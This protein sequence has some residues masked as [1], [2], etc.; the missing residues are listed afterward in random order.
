[1]SRRRHALS[2]LAAV[3]A[4]LV[5]AAPAVAQGPPPPTS[6]SGATVE[7]VAHGVTTPTSFAFAGATVF[8]GSGPN[9]DRKHNPN[10][11]T[12]LFTLAGGAATKVPGTPGVV[13]GLAYQN[14]VLYISTFNRILAYRG[15]NGTTFSGHSVIARAAGKLP[16]F[17]GLAF[18]PNGRLYVGASLDAKSDAKKGPGRYA[19]TVISMRPNGHRWLIVAR[20]LRQPFQ[21][22]FPDGQTSPFV[23]DLAQETGR[24]PDDQVVVAKTG[25]NFGFPTCER[26]ALSECPR[27]TKPFVLF[28]RHTS[29]MGIG[30]IGATLYLAQFGKQQVVSMPVAGGAATPFLTKFAA[31]VI[32]LATH[33]G[34]VYVGDLTGTIY[35]VAVPAA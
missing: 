16:G 35:R 1:L 17:N 28:P 2:A 3:T 20:G 22:T 14:G 32:G 24:V 30:S 31:P 34:F 26:R 10:G 23:S 13:A 29:P 33:E 4:A 21:L 8:A 9:E 12:G 27:F 11:K 5:A 6:P 25:S 15:W 7:T 19:N 18:G